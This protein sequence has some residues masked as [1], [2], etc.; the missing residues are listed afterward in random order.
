MP[1]DPPTST[2]LAHLIKLTPSYTTELDHGQLY[3][4]CFLPPGAAA[5]A[6]VGS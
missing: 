1:P 5:L 2:Y 3:C 4:L 6:G